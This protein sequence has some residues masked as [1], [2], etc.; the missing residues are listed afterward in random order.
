MAGVGL[1]QLR[2]A[3][4]GKAERRPIPLAPFHVSRVGWRHVQV[5]GMQAQEP[6]NP[7]R[8]RKIAVD[9]L[10]QIARG[11]TALYLC[12]SPPLRQPPH[13]RPMSRPVM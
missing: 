1:F 4:L 7:A 10:L 13:T 12:H 3:G 9:D 8:L 2:L 5:V 11:S 6:E